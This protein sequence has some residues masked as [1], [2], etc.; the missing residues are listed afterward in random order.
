MKGGFARS[1]GAAMKRL[2]LL[3]TV[4]C[5]AGLPLTA[6]A[7]DYGPGEHMLA[8]E[9][10]APSLPSTRND[11][12]GYAGF[13]TSH[14]APMDDG[15]STAAASSNNDDADPPAPAPAPKRTVRRATAP[16]H[17]APG[18]AKPGHGVL[19]WQS[20]LPGSIQ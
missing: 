4:L 20:L 7:L 10:S 12:N 1:M 5:A 3:L 2:P 15:D 8:A 19:T 13:T 16:I 6:A 11:D 14:R 18:P 9:A 17:A